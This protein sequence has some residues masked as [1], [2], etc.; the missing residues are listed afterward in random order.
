MTF[1]H[2]SSLPRRLPVSGIFASVAV[3]LFVAVALGLW[4]DQL[5]WQFRESGIVTYGSVL[6]LGLI[7]WTS[8]AIGKEP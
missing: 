1:A 2:S 8:F 6:L 7:S 3:L 5:D 4:R